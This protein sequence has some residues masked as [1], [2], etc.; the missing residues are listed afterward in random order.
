MQPQSFTHMG[1]AMGLKW[2][3][4]MSPHATPFKSLDHARFTVAPKLIIYDN[5]C[6][7][8]QYCLNR[9][10]AF[11]GH[12]QFAVDRFHWRDHVGCSA[13]YST[14]LTSISLLLRWE[15]SIRT[16]TLGYNTSRDN[17]HT[18]LHTI[19]FSSVTFFGSEKYGCK[20][21]TWCILC[22]FELN[23]HSCLKVCPLLC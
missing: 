17:L 5:A 14:A 9:V 16:L 7:L 23:I 13:S 22:M 3:V 20:E 21:E 18:C 2:W 19:L 6:K 12:T 4:P 10:P 15:R 11:F 1:Y 8:H